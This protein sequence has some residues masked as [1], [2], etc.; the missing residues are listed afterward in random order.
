MDS[1]RILSTIQ[2]LYVCP[3]DKHMPKL[4]LCD[5]MSLGILLATL[6]CDKVMR[7][8]FFQLFTEFGDT[9]LQTT[10]E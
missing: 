2:L 3:F 5:I 8:A 10:G 4:D 9:I 6:Y 7:D 1:G